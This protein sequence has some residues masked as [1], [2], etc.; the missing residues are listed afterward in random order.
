MS[1]SCFGRSPRRMTRPCTAPFIVRLRE[2]HTLTQAGYIVGTPG[3]MSPEQAE[4]DP[5]LMSRASDVWSLGVILFQ[6]LTRRLPFQGRSPADTVVK[7]IHEEVPR[8]TAI[9]KQIPPALEAVC[10]KALQKDVTKRYATAKELATDLGRFLRGEPVTAKAPSPFEALGRKVKRN[11]IPL[12]VGAVAVVVIAAILA[13]VGLRGSSKRDQMRAEARLLMKK[14]QWADA[15]ALWGQLAG[16]GEADEAYRTCV[17]K[18]ESVDLAGAEAKKRERKRE[19]LARDADVDVSK[20]HDLISTPTSRHIFQSAV[21]AAEKSSQTVIDTDPTKP[22]GWFR[23]GKLRYQLLDE[24]CLVELTKAIDLGLTGPQGHYLRARMT[25]LWLYRSTLY[26]YLPYAS[27]GTLMEGAKADAAEAIRRG[28][29]SSERR[30]V[31]TYLSGVEGHSDAAEVEA[32]KILKSNPTNFDA[33]ELLATCLRDQE[34][35]KEAEEPCLAIKRLRPNTPIHWLSLP[36]ILA[37]TDPKRVGE[38]VQEMTGLDSENWLVWLECAIAFKDI[39]QA[40]RALA[41]A[42]KAYAV[43]SKAY[44]ALHF[45]GDLLY[46]R[47]ARTAEAKERYARVVKEGTGCV[48]EYRYF[49]AL[50][51]L[52]QY[53]RLIR[54]A[55]EFIAK[56]GPPA[57]EQSM[58]V[59]RR[60]QA[61]RAYAL[62]AKGRG[63]EAIQAIDAAIGTVPRAAEFYYA[64]AEIRIILKKDLDQARKMIAQGRVQSDATRDQAEG[65]SLQQRLD[66]IEKR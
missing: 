54:E 6:M 22:E 17:E 2:G 21:L 8:P 58:G 30:L 45:A 16:D 65:D 62:L 34:L 26:G 49:R 60:V 39:D 36:T 40:D 66:A 15:K 47:L 53:E 9:V 19:E 44:S 43:N 10:L 42:D 3:Y 61:Y 50:G 32:R 29:E 52:A 35:Y 33:L 41:A 46:D 1:S 11:R 64:A 5:R 23:L 20:V 59:F 63:D 27:Y 51:G 38:A 4:G 56:L 12:I 37:H 14:Q 28:L 24:R 55:D 57:N 31:D 25:L 18:L 48:S 7:V 13:I